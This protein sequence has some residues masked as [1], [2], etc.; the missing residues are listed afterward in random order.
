MNKESERKRDKEVGNVSILLSKLQ[1]KNGT[2]NH[3]H[4]VKECVQKLLQTQP[5]KNRQRQERFN[6]K[7]KHSIRGRDRESK[8]KN[9]ITK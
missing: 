7:L 4:D 1:Y 6:G 2:I 8:H 9:S 3:N 5:R